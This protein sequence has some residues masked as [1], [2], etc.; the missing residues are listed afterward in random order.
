MKLD[1][2]LRTENLIRCQKKFQEFEVNYKFELKNLRSEVNIR[3]SSDFNEEISRLESI[4]DRF[5]Y[6][7]S[8]NP[9]HIE[10]YKIVCF[11]FF[12]KLIERFDLIV[13]NKI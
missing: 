12:I 4:F 8:D 3:V 2:S 7:F 13:L 6:E 9:Q 10:S 5:K 1:L 11:V